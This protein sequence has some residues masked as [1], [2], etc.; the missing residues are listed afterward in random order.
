MKRLVLFFIVYLLFSTQTVVYSEVTLPRVIGSNM[1][2]QR[3]MQAPIWGWASAGEEI[4]ITLSTE[5]EGV[6]PIS[7]TTAVTDAEGNWQTKLPAMA[8]GGPLYTPNQGQQ[9]R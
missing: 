1:V 9:Y 7:T 8:A 4:T 3:D 2:L 5:A 6:E